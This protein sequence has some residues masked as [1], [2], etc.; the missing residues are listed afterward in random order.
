MRDR[1]PGYGQSLLEALISEGLADHFAVA[2]LRIPPP[3]WTHALTAE[4]LDNALAK[5]RP[6]FDRRPY[7]HSRWFFG[8]GDIPRWTGYALGY[9]LVTKYLATHP[10]QTAASLVDV[11]AGA[12]RQPG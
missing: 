2:L 5:A 8:A 3:P 9:H 4:Q 6:E 7:D 10:D 1:G 11:P 12:F